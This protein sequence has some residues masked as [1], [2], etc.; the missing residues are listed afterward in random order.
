MIKLRTSVRTLTN[1]R[2]YSLVELIVAMTIFAV[3]LMTATVTFT[4]VVR[5]S[6]KSA[7]QRSVQQEAR[8]SIEEIARQARTANSVDYG[9]YAGS[10]SGPCSIDV[11]KVLALNTFDGS[12]FKRLYY[13]YD[14]TSKAIY[15]YEEAPRQPSFPTCATIQDLASNPE[16][17]MTANNVDVLGAAFTILP[18]QNPDLNA[19][20]QVANTTCQAVNATQPRVQIA[21]NMRS[22]SQSNNKLTASVLFQ[23]TAVLRSYPYGPAVPVPSATPTP[24]PASPGSSPRPSTQPSAS[25][26]PWY[27]PNC[28]PSPTPG[29][30]TG[31]NMNFQMDV[32]VVYK[33]DSSGNITDTAMMGPMNNPGSSPQTGTTVTYDYA[34]GTY[35]GSDGA[36]WNYDPANNVQYA[37][38]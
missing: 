9:F 7:V 2:G 3:V 20:C 4:A 14:D 27:K 28:K 23:T 21:A 6:Q 29:G 38:V 8:Y 13:Y 19:A 25:T 32:K 36:Q 1:Q 22:T 33:Y 26:C 24:P 35:V 31:G 5:G 16:A 12:Q 30:S 34:T 11:G 18:R 17:R 10:P 37:S 15:R